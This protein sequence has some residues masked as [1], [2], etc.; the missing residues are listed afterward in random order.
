MGDFGADV[1]KVEHPRGDTLRTLGWRKDDVSL[2]WL[3]I[4][5]NKRCVTLNLSDPRGQELLR[6]ILRDS[7]V[8]IENF[9]PGTLE[10]WNLDPQHLRQL[11]PTL[12]V[13]RVSGFGQDGPYRNRPGFGTLA[14][15][16]SGFAHVN[17]TGHPYCRRSL[18]P[19][20]SQPSPAPSQP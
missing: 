11:N 6:R 3:F 19:M 8:L 12:V 17:G 13:V 15:A 9:R 20:A 2:W 5:R 1:I 4:A 10:R 16:F 7:D 18:S 14:E